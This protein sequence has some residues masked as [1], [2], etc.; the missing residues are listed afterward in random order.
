LEDDCASLELKMSNVKIQMSNGG[1]LPI[2]MVEMMAAF[3][4]NPDG[5]SSRFPA[6][7]GHA[8]KHQR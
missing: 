2:C 7:A 8:V 6:K 4:R 1:I 5:L 3:G